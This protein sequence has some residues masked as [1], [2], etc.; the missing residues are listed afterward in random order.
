MQSDAWWK[1][2]MEEKERNKNNSKMEKTMFD[3]QTI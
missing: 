2:Q 1:Q 3:N